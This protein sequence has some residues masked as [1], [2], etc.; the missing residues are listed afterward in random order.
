MIIMSARNC[1]EEDV[2]LNLIE[3]KINQEIILT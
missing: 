1:A 3:K 2:D